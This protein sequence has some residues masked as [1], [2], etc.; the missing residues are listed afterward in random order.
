MN[1]VELK[2]KTKGV[3]LISRELEDSISAL[4]FLIVWN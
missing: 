4:G 3:F 1:L 2:L